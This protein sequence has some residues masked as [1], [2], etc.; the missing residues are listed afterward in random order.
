MDQR[1]LD[2]R[3]QYK[4]VELLV[5]QG[6]LTHT[7]LVFGVAFTVRTLFPNE[8][9]D[10]VAH[11]ASQGVLA[12]RKWIVA[13]GLLYFRGHRLPLDLTYSYVERF[14]KRL[15][16]HLYYQIIGLM[17]RYQKSMEIA[18]A[19]AYE[20]Y[21]RHNW[22]TYG[23]EI[24]KNSFDMI[25]GV[26]TLWQFVNLIEDR[27]ESSEMHWNHAKFIASAM[28]PKGVKKQMSKD[29]QAKKKRESE[30]EEY[31]L[32]SLRYLE[33]QNESDKP[34]LVNAKT[35]DELM[36]EYK[37][38]VA[39]EQDNHDLIV[40]NYKDRIREGMEQRERE[41]AERVQKLMGDGERGVFAATRVAGEEAKEGFK[42]S[43]RTLGHEGSQKRLYSRFL[44]REE[45][46]GDFYV[47]NAGQVRKR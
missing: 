1:S 26:Q 33:T 16:H 7:V 11:T 42:G 40:Q 12:Y 27:F 37:R 31:I 10:L 41:A 23:K 2:R 19:Y 34:I 30:R 43:T 29:E 39:G 5:E 3:P 44:G 45:V 21:G 28:S 4:D 35:D 24:P 38:W 17:N 25:N 13:R 36:E 15:T 14:P 47:D 9:R 20:S 8:V 46:G 22:Y 18:Q 6:Y 32:K